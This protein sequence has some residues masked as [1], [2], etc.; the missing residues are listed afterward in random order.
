MPIDAIPSPPFSVADGN[1]SGRFDEAPFAKDTIDHTEAMGP[2]PPR[3]QNIDHP[4]PELSPVGVNTAPI[5]PSI[6]D[7][8][9]PGTKP[10][11]SDRDTAF[12]FDNSNQTSLDDSR[13]ERPFSFSDLDGYDSTEGLRAKAVKSDKQ[14]VSTA[15]YGGRK[16][17][18][19][20]AADD[21]LQNDNETT[22]ELFDEPEQHY[23]AS[24]PA[25]DSSMNNM[26][27]PR[28]GFTPARFDSLE[29]A[30]GTLK[31]PIGLESRQ[32]AELSYKA[33][34]TNNFGDSVLDGHYSHGDEGLPP[35]LSPNLNN[36]V[37]MHTGFDNPLPAENYTF[38]G[39][40]NLD[41]PVRDHGSIGGTTLYDDAP[42]AMAEGYNGRDNLYGMRCPK[43]SLTSRILLNVQK[44]KIQV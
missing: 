14:E 17:N 26:A 40:T 34:Q 36:T 5:S 29:S 38:D 2:T 25:M 35:P 28:D 8:A 41:K 31:S 4:A 11:T 20:D 44:V 32:A 33:P 24:S 37:A 1:A 27:T 6:Y 16:K 22:L 21:G 15:P 19:K 43:S 9:S 39:N 30:Q 10:Q 12:D 23:K 13:K 42:L 18:S 7:A 3:G